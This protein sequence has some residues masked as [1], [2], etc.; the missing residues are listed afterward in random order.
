MYAEEDR[1]RDEAISVAAAS[2]AGSIF[3]TAKNHVWEYLE[4]IGSEPINYAT[5]SYVLAGRNSGDKYVELVSRIQESTGS[6]NEMEKSKLMNPEELNI[7]LIPAINT[8]GSAY[9]PDYEASKNLLAAL[10][11][12]SRLSFNRPGPY[13]ITLYQPISRIQKDQPVVD[14]LYVDLTN[15]NKGAIAE[16]VRTYKQ[17]VLD[18]KMNGLNK[19]SSLRL[20]LLNLAFMTEESIGF[21]KTASASLDPIFSGGS[22]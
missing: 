21:A 13:I 17:N 19:L 2:I 4:K 22:N 8:D 18:K 1:K 5:Y 9:K 20:S 6:A 12:K 14:M 10:G 11:A 7:F 3:S 15:I 16:L